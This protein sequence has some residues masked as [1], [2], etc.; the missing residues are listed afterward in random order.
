MGGMASQI[1]NTSIVYLAASLGQHQ[2]LSKFPIP[3]PLWEEYIGKGQENGKPFHVVM[4]SCVVTVSDI[5][6]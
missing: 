2:K 1:T 3:G 6:T 5:H 4:L